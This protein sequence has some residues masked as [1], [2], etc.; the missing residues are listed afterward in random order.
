M[1][2]LGADYVGRSPLSTLRHRRDCGESPVEDICGVA[3]V[4]Q[5]VRG[6]SITSSRRRVPHTWCSAAWMPWAVIMVDRIFGPAPRVGRAAPLAAILVWQGQGRMR[7]SA[8]QRADLAKCASVDRHKTM[9][10]R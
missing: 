5:L 2:T 9:G 8:T 4:F 3:R 7:T 1:I 6:R 10:T